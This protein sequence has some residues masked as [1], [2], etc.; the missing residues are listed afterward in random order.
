MHEEN[1]LIRRDPTK[2]RA[3]DL[4]EEKPWTNMMRVPLVGTVAA[5][6]PI[7]AE[8]NIEEVFSVPSALLGTRDDTFMLR[9][10]GES[11]INA[12]IFDGD[13]IFVREQSTARDGEIV[14]ALVDQEEATVKRVFFETGRV[15]LQPENDAMQPFYETDVKILGKVIG[16]YRHIM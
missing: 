12:G 7:C 1:G 11:M 3:I 4:L 14:V 9:V 13:Y 16:V 15:R 6:V 8:E 10:Q 2:P 5:G